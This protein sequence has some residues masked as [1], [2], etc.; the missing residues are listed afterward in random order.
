VDG[1]VWEWE[2]DTG[3]ER[4]ASGAATRADAALV[5]EL[6]DQAPAAWDALPEAEDFQALAERT[7]FLRE[8]LAAAARCG[9]AEAAQPVLLRLRV[10]LQAQGGRWAV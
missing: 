2:A 4:P 8:A 3:R 1:Q 6:L 5:G 9:R 7:L 10:L